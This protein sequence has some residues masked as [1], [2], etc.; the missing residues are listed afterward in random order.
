M[1][2]WLK[3]LFQARNLAV[4]VHDGAMAFAALVVAFVLRL[5]VSAFAAESLVFEA[6]GA[7]AAVAVVVAVFTGLYR[8]VWHYV[9]TKDALNILHAA[10]LTV[11]IFVP[12]WFVATRLEGFPRSVPLIAWFVLIL[13]WAGPRLLVRLFKDRHLLSRL[14]AKLQGTRVLLVGAGPEAEQFIRAVQR[15]PARPFRVLGMVTANPARLGQVI[16]G[17]DVLGRDQ[18]LAKIIDGL[19]NRGLAPERIVVV[20][21]A[22]SGDELRRIFDVAE[23]SGCGLVR[24]PPATDLR[25]LD[26]LA[27][28]PRPLA[29]EDLLSRPQARLERDAIARLVKGRRVLITGAGGSI[30]AELVRQIAALAPEALTLIDHG[31][32]NLYTV[33]QEVRELHPDLAVISWLADVRDAP[34]LTEIFQAARPELVFHAA[35]LKHVPLV[36]ANPLEGL[37]TNAVGTRHVADACVAVG[38]A[39]MVLVSTDKA[40]NPAGIMGAA[41]RAAEVYCQALDVRRAGPRFITVRFGNVL[42]SAGSV[43]PLFQKQLDA[44]GPLTVTHPEIERYF[45]TTR[46]AVELVLQASAL[47]PLRNDEGGIYVLDMGAPIKILDLA[48]QMIRLAGKTPDIDIQI[49]FTGLRP[50]EKLSEELFHGEEPPMATDMPGIL[51][52]RPRVADHAVVGGKLAA[53]ADACRRRDQAASL[54]VLADLVPE[55]HREPQPATKPYLK[56]VK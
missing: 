42:G 53:L 22:I 7:F 23:A 2:N 38:A 4:V 16:Q 3:T 19:K 12:L 40:V 10:T 13:A 9:S 29:L 30:G 47:G 39:V 52:A 49:K 55:M 50:G 43:V 18:D 45:M 26:D 28:Q 6:A 1:E 37:L 51:I 41:K 34:R 56:I 17:V 35:A 11:L 36:E 21:A 33:D 32:F 15:A 14:S 48:R 5:G 24:V 31:E 46:E 27:L 54:A 8:H 44:G 25:A 20:R